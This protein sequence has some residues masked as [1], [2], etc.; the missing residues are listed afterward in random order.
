MKKSIVCAA[1]MFTAAAFIVTG[2]A[3]IASAQQGKGAGKQAPAKQ[4]L[5]PSGP[6]SDDG[7]I[8]VLKVQGNV[9]MLVGAPS[10][11][12]ALQVGDSGVLLV[13]TMTTAVSDKVVA[14]IRK[15]SSEPIRYLVNT[16]VHVDHTGGNANFVKMG[17]LLFA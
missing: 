13:D 9:Y 14:A 5:V 11:N 17:A 7:Q 3:Q 8:H 4:N 1:V 15:I 6:R 16:H 10:G 2:P 12:I